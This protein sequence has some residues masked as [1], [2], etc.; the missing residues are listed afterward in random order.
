MATQTQIVLP[1]DDVDP[2][3]LLPPRPAGTDKKSKNP[4][5]LRL[6]PGLRLLLP[7]G[8]VVPTVSGE[9]VADKRKNLLWIES[10][11]GRV[12]PTP[13]SQSSMFDPD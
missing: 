8:E 11:G 12:R 6:G 2:T 13:L 4:P 3:Q 7:S 5:P 1:G 9:L 10:E